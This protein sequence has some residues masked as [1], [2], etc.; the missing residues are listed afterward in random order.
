MQGYGPRSRLL[1]S[2]FAA[3]AAV[4]ALSSCGIS[5]DSNPSRI[6]IP[7]T[8]ALSTM[9]EP[10]SST[11]TTTS[12]LDEREPNLPNWTIGR[13]VALAPRVENSRYHQGAVSEQAPLQD[14]SGFH[15]STPDGAVACSTGLNGGATLACRLNNETN[16]PAR[17]SDQPSSCTW[18]GNYATLTSDGP[19]HGACTNEFEVLYRSSIV[20]YGHTIA[21]SRFSCLVETSGIFCLESRSQSG[22]SVTATGY[23]TIFAADRAP[24]SILGLSDDTT[25]ETP[26]NTTT[27]T[28]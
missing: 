16:P 23:H 20:D 28:R 11:T 27:P 3:L 1:F 24:E 4:M 9:T 25:S 12:T 13:V 14:T 26:R 8:N 19:E 15:F 17:P 21:I 7:P 10:E 5:T 22:F 18:A 6:V 2:A